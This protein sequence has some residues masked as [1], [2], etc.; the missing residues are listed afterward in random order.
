M[1]KVAVIHTS[2]VSLEDIKALFKEILPDVKMLN[3]IDDSL[4]AEVLENDGVT[5]DIIRRM[6]IYAMEFER[7]G[8]DLIL[9]QC[10]SVSEVMNIVKKI[11]KIPVVKI[12]EAMAEEAVMTGNIISVIATVSSTLNPSI[13]LI[14][15]MA[16]KYNKNVSIRRCLC[17]G[18]F[19]VL[20]KEKNVG[21]HNQMVIENIKEEAK[22]ADVIILA[23]GSMITLLPY[24]KDID[25]P[26]LSS[27]RSGVLR[28]AK[29][30]G[31]DRKNENNLK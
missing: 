26:I 9:N 17:K 11:V 28:V 5:K 14:K 27:P 23:Q 10:S 16:E 1:K 21:K 30:L 18:A 31:Y 4:L 12:D 20:V 19:D 6:C 7:M 24:I 15:E 25:K 2:T 29:I 3:I 22:H 13:N 8:V